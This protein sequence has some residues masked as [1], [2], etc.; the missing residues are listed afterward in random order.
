MMLVMDIEPLVNASKRLT[1][2]W[3][4]YQTNIQDIQIR[5]GLIQRFEFTY[6]ISHKMIKRFFGTDL[7]KSSRN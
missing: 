2:G 3:E 6:E 4:R 1:E 7:G 5:D